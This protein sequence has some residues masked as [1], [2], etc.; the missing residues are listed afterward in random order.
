MKLSN[1]VHYTQCFN[2]ISNVEPTA[3]ISIRCYS[4]ENIPKW[5]VQEYLVCWLDVLSGSSALSYL[6]CTGLTT[7]D[8]LWLRWIVSSHTIIDES[9]HVFHKSFFDFGNIFP[10]TS[11]T[12]DPGVLLDLWHYREGSKVYVTKFDSVGDHLDN[13]APINIHG[14]I[15][16]HSQLFFDGRT[17][18]KS[19]IPQRRTE[20]ARA[21]KHLG[22]LFWFVR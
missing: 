1:T 18:H 7:N 13:S 12:L 5:I 21:I 9:G 19:L 2:H 8:P 16:K 10:F 20:R 17:K 15:F 4:K 14:I 22:G 11:F 3:R 6:F